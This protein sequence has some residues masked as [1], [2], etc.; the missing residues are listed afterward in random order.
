[1][2]QVALRTTGRINITGATIITTPIILRTRRPMGIRIIITSLMP[3]L[4]AA[5]ITV[6]GDLMAVT[7][8]IKS[9]RRQKLWR[10]KVKVGVDYSPVL[11]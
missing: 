10:R 7:D 2:Q 1:M 8:I 4:S 3:R 5:A 6:A 9:N 11:R